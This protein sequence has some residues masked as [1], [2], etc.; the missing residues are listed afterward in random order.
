MSRRNA[1]LPDAVVLAGGSARR[2]G[3]VDKPG[4]YVGSATLLDRVLAAL[5]PYGT[6]VVVGPP[7][8][9]VRPVAWTRESP[10]GGGPVAGLAAGLSLVTAPQVLVIAGDMPFLTTPV[11]ASLLAAVSEDGALLVDDEGRDQ[12]LC[13]AWRTSSLRAAVAGV[14]R[15]KDVVASLAFVRV[16]SPVGVAAPW[17]DCDTPDDLTAARERA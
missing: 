1:R 14:D 15:M 11:L 13:S 17:T 6:A 9:T 10:P 4:L 7:R 8:P 12:Y 2:L 16:S 3:G 5:P